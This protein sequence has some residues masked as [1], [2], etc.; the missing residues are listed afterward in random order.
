[1]QGHLENEPIACPQGLKLHKH[2]ALYRDNIRSIKGSTTSRS[3][4][5]R[6]LSSAIIY[7]DLLSMLH[8]LRKS[9]KRNR[10]T[11]KSP[12]EDRETRA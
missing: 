1:M 9:L 11:L 6:R 5:I 2:Y 8:K 3:I 10:P 4:M 7:A 12:E